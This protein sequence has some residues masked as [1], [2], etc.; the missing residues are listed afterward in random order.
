MKKII[1]TI[2]GFIITLMMFT[3]V[4]TKIASAATFTSKLECTPALPVGPTVCAQVYGTR[5]EV[6]EV[7]VM[8]IAATGHPWKGKVRFFMQQNSEEGVNFYPVWRW[9]IAGHA[10][11]EECIIFQDYIKI[12]EGLGGNGTWQVSVASAP[13]S[14]ET[15]HIL[16]GKIHT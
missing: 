7:Y 1:A 6:Q 13:G 9:S 16:K 2:L 5:L 14:P 15:G 4:S 3:G 12:R 10:N 11:N 8:V